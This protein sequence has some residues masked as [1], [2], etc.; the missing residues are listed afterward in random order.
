MGFKSTNKFETKDLRTVAYIDSTL[1]ASMTSVQEDDLNN[2]HTNQYTIELS[3]GIGGY[4]CK[5]YYDTL[6]DKAY[7]VKD[8]GLYQVGI[9]LHLLRDMLYHTVY[10]N[11]WRSIPGRNRFCTVY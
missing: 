11:R 2:N 10:R 4:S 3:N 5:L 9:D 7:L 8:G 1:N 6:Y